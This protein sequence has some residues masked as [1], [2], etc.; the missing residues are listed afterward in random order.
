MPTPKTTIHPS[1]ATVV[2][3]VSKIYTEIKS[4][5]QKRGLLMDAVHEFKC[6]HQVLKIIDFPDES[7][8]WYPLV[9][10]EW[11]W[12]GKNIPHSAQLLL[13]IAFIYMHEEL[14][15]TNEG[16]FNLF[17]LKSFLTS[18]NRQNVAKELKTT[19]FENIT[20][21]NGCVHLDEMNGW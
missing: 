1:K 18:I 8:K 4:S 14:A 13:A 15:F 3:T 12:F 17:M 19:Y 16:K 7:S 5:S 10:S 9:V 2:R 20:L 21:E 6:I 11:S